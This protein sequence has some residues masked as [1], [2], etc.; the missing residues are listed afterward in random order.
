MDL[1]QPN[2]RQPQH[3]HHSFYL[4]FFT[5]KQLVTHYSLFFF[6]LLLVTCIFFSSPSHSLT[7]LAFF[8]RIF[9][10]NQHHSIDENSKVCDYSNGKWVRDENYSRQSYTEKCPFL[11]PGFRCRRNG[12]SDVDYVN[13]RWQPK[14]CHLP[15]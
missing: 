9:P 3:I 15:R 7:S 2:S 11:D 14:E 8:S 1:L 5:K 12:R 6:V 10:K 4:P 13:W